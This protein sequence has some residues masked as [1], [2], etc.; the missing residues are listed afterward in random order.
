MPEVIVIQPKN[1][2]I[3][4]KTEFV[5]PTAPSEIV[6][7]EEPGGAP[8]L[9]PGVVKSSDTRKRGIRTA[10]LQDYRE[11]CEGLLKIDRPE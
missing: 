5:R 11:C 6:V 1:P 10:A 3:G 7:D 9:D 8:T 4:S 2:S